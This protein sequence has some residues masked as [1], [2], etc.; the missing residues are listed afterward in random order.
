M[1]FNMAK[2]KSTDGTLVEILTLPQVLFETIG[3]IASNYP[4]FEQILKKKYSKSKTIKPHPL[5]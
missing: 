1:E 3:Y 4:S 2:E 5:Y